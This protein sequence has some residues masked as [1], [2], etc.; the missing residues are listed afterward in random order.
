MDD[1]DMKEF[2]IPSLTQQPNPGRGM[3]VQP[4]TEYNVSVS[5]VRRVVRYIRQSL[6]RLGRFK[7]CVMD[8]K[9]ETKGLLC[10]DVSTRWNSTYLMLDVAQKFEKVFDAYDDVNVMFKADLICSYGYPKKEDWEKLIYVASVL[11]PR[12][13]LEYVKC[14][15]FALHG[16]EKAVALFVNVIKAISELFDEYMKVL[17]PEFSQCEVGDVSCNSQVGVNL[18]S[19]EDGLFFP[20]YKRF[21]K[22]SRKDKSKTKL[23]KYLGEDDEED[24]SEFDVL[25]WWRINSDR[26]PVL[27]TLAREVMAVFFSIVAS[28]STFS[29][30]GRALDRYQSS[31]TSKVV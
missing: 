3:K 1:V 24:G 12:K 31:L 19:S 27:S 4:P 20:K 22:D 28:E 10:L 16:E 9:V 23:D 21:K 2:D 17:K 14:A 25:D 26:Y 7:E 6:A 11:N 29:T 5:M 8:L 18:N 30:G 13:K 15:L